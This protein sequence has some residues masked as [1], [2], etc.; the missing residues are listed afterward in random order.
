MTG[1]RLEVNVHIVTSSTTAT[2]NIACVV[3]RAD[4][5]HRHRDRAGSRPPRPVLT[6]DEKRVELARRAG[7]HRRRDTDIAI[8]ERG[9][10][11][12]YRL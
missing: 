3:N 1:A 11:W 8:F 6:Q 4:A 10:L 12:H 5:S 9:S 7:R 2:Q